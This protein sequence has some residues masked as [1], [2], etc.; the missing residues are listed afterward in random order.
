MTTINLNEEL[1]DQEYLPYSCID[2]GEQTCYTVM[3]Y[4]S[5][6][7][8]Q[9][10]T[11]I[12][13]SLGYFKSG[14]PLTAVP[15]LIKI[16]YTLSPQFI[17]D[18]NFFYM[19]HD[20]LWYSNQGERIKVLNLCLTTPDVKVELYNR[21]RYIHLPINYRILID[22]INSIGIKYDSLT[23]EERHKYWTST[24]INDTLQNIAQY[25]EPSNTSKI[26]L[27]KNPLNTTF[28]FKVFARVNPNLNMC[29]S[30]QDGISGPDGD[31]V[32]LRT[33]F[34]IIDYEEFQNNGLRHIPH[35]FT[36]IIIV[37]EGRDYYI[38]TNRNG[39]DIGVLRCIDEI[40]IYNSS[41]SNCIYSAQEGFNSLMN[42]YEMIACL[43]DGN[44][45]IP[46]QYEN[47]IYDITYT[48]YLSNAFNT[49]VSMRNNIRGVRNDSTIVHSFNESIWRPV[50]NSESSEYANRIFTLRER[51]DNQTYLYKPTNEEENDMELYLRHHTPHC[52]NMFPL[53]VGVRAKFIR[54]FVTQYIEQWRERQIRRSNQE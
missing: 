25:Y 24:I 51:H 33:K 13:N 34:A 52:K 23:E 1:V 6:I 53:A 44:Y 3:F 41:H 16:Y 37:K 36:I 29:M 10:G 22:R 11:S 27:F 43:A 20:E 50:S 2:F 28:S 17:T 54:T 4:N 31:N 45:Q 14:Q 26:I 49:Y 46:C 30:S 19:D 8:Y 21:E 47:Y 9:N 40:R 15:G 12:P 48:R 35:E 5:H 39:D 7:R 18:G 32:I 38:S 42:P